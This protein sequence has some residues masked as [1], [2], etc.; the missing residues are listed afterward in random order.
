M[1]E[2]FFEPAKLQRY[3][4]LCDFLLLEI[5]DAIWITEIYKPHM[6]NIIEIIKKEVRDVHSVERYDELAEKKDLCKEIIVFFSPVHPAFYDS[7]KAILVRYLGRKL[8]NLPHVRFYDNYSL[9]QFTDVDFVD[10]CHL[11]GEGAAKYTKLLVK[12]MQQ[13]R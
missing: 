5:L 4:Y 2:N 11:S 6:D 9:I 10:H 7:E 12:Q 3:P 8:K 1:R 13:T